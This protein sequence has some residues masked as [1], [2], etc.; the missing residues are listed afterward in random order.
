MGGLLNTSVFSSMEE[1]RRVEKD[2]PEEDGEYLAI[3]DP[4]I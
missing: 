1:R 2:N 4:I 3:H